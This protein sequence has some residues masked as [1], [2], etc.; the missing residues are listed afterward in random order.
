MASMPAVVETASKTIPAGSVPRD[1]AR[2]RVR[3]SRN[4]PAATAITPTGTLRKNTQRQ[5]T[6]ATIRPPSTGPDARPT[7]CA[8]ACT[9]SAA[10]RFRAGMLVTTSATLFACSIAAPTAWTSRNAIS[11]PIEV[12]RPQP[13][14]A[15]ANTTN[16]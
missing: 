5:P 8:A 15:A 9:P 2:R 13:A 1:S 4:T 16:P 11:M 6:A 10:R 7:A 12:A 14:D 3:G